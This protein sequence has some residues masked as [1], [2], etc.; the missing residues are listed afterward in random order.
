[1]SAISTR[2]PAS[3]Q[4]DRVAYGNALDALGTASLAQALLEDIDRIEQ[5]F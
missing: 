2:T 3:T 4:T 5:T 1:M